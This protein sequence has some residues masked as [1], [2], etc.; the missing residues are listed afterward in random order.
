M[1]AAWNHVAKSS[2]GPNSISL[3]GIATEKK[4]STHFAPSRTVVDMDTFAR[5]LSHAWYECERQNGSGGEGKPE[6]WM[7]LFLHTLTF[8]LHCSLAR[9][10][11]LPFNIVTYPKC[12]RVFHTNRHI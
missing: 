10:R 2:P 1:F 11:F 7:H 5:I 4:E 9:F 3:F 12:S 8:A 6:E